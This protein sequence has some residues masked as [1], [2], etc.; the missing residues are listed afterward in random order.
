MKT[1]SDGHCA[2]NSFALGLHN[3]FIK[4]ASAEDF[5]LPE[6][7]VN[8]AIEMGEEWQSKKDI[9]D[10]LSVTREEILH[11]LAHPYSAQPKY[12][13]IIQRRL[14]PIFRRMALEYLEKHYE[15]SSLDASFEMAAFDYIKYD[16]EATNPDN[17]F[18]LIPN[19][20]LRLEHYRQ[21]Q[22]TYAQLLDWWNTTGRQLYF[23]HMK[24]GAN[25]DPSTWGSQVEL[26]VLAAIFHVN[27]IFTQSGL[28]PQV[29]GFP[30]GCIDVGA[31]DLPDE[32]TEDTLEFL[33]N[34]N[35]LSK[36]YGK[37]VF[38]KNFDEQIKE[39]LYLKQ[40]K[41]KLLE[42]AARPLSIGEWLAEI[43]T[44]EHDRVVSILKAHGVLT[45]GYAINDGSINPITELQTGAPLVKEIIAR[46]SAVDERIVDYLR[47]YYIASQPS[48]RVNLEGNHWSF[49]QGHEVFR[50]R[51]SES[52]VSENTRQPEGIGLKSTLH[53]VTYQLALLLLIFKRAMDKKLNF[54]EATEWD[55][56][57]KFDDAVI[58]FQDPLAAESKIILHAY[59]AKHKQDDDSMITDKDLFDMSGGDFSLFK[60]FL[61]FL[62]LQREK[63][64]DEVI[65]DVV[66]YTNAGIDFDAKAKEID[67]KKLLVEA[68]V[69]NAFIQTE[70]A[71]DG[72]HYKFDLTRKE[73]LKPLYQLLQQASQLE[74]LAKCLAEHV[75]ANKSFELRD[76]ILKMYHLALVNQIF[77]LKKKCFMPNFIQDKTGN[78]VLTKLLQLFRENLI[79]LY[80]KNK[81]TDF[82]K[83][84]E[85]LPIKK[86]K[87][88][89][90]FGKVDEIK[91]SPK[92]KNPENSA[93]AFSENEAGNVV[94]LNNK[95]MAGL[96]GKQ[97]DELRGHIIVVDPAS[98]QL[99]FST[100]FCSG[101]GLPGNLM[102][103]RTALIRNLGL[104]AAQAE[105]S[106]KQYTLVIKDF[107]TCEDGDIES[108]AKLPTEIIGD[109]ITPT[110]IEEFLQHLTFS[111]NQP[112]EIELFN[113]LQAELG[114]A[115]NVINSEFIA[116]LFQKKMLDWLKLKKGTFL[117]EKDGEEM[118]KMARSLLSN[119]VLMGQTLE[120][121]AQV[122]QSNIAF[123]TAF[124]VGE[125]LKHSEQVHLINCP[126]GT[127]LTGIKLFKSIKAIDQ[128]QADDSFIFL[129]VKSALNLE[130]QLKQAFSKTS[131]LVIEVDKNL[132]DTETARLITQFE[133][134][135]SM[136][137]EIKI[138][139]LTQDDTQLISEK[140]KLAHKV[141]EDSA[142]DFHALTEESKAYLLSKRVTING[143][144]KAVSE[145][146]EGD[147]DW[148][149]STVVEDL[150]TSPDDSPI[151][152][153]LP[154]TTMSHFDLECYVDRIFERRITLDETV[155]S[156]CSDLILYISPATSETDQTIPDGFTNVIKFLKKYNLLKKQLKATEDKAQRTELQKSLDKLI[157]STTRLCL[158]DASQ[159]NHIARCLN[160]AFKNIQI[161]EQDRKGQLLWKESCG[162]IEGVRAYFQKAVS[163]EHEETDFSDISEHKIIAAEPGMG[164]SAV[165]Q[166]ML[167]SDQAAAKKSE[168]EFEFLV[169]NIDLSKSKTFINRQN[170]SNDNSIIQFLTKIFNLPFLGIHYL[171][172]KLKQ[173]AVK[174]YLDGFD[175]INATQQEK[176]CKFLK[177][178]QVT[179]SGNKIVV[180]TRRHKTKQLEDALVTVAYSLRQVQMEEQIVY[181]KNY[182]SE[183]F[184]KQFEHID[185]VRV[186]Q[187]ARFVVEKFSKDLND[188][189]NEF[190]GIPLQLRL[191]AESIQE[192]C[193]E[194]YLSD[195]AEPDAKLVYDKIAFY[196]KII[197]KKIQI[198]F[199]EKESLSSDFKLGLKSSMKQAII[200]V[201][202]EIAFQLL[203][204]DSNFAQEV[205]S[206]RH[207]SAS[208]LNDIGLVEEI[209]GEF[210]FVHRTYGEYLAAYKIL[211]LL[212]VEESIQK[213]S[214][215]IK[216]ILTQ[217]FTDKGREAILKFIMTMLEKSNN[218]RLLENWNYIISLSLLPQNIMSGS[219]KSDSTKL[220][221]AYTKKNKHHD[222]EQDLSSDE[223]I[224]DLDELLNKEI[225][226]AKKY[227]YGY[228]NWSRGA[229]SGIDCFVYFFNE[230]Y[231]QFSIEQMNKALD[232][233]YLLL[234][235]NKKSTKAKA[236]I[237][238]SLPKFVYHYINLGFFPEK[239][240]QYENEKIF[241]F[242]KISRT[243]AASSTVDLS[244][245]Q[246]SLDLAYEKL[247]Q[248][249]DSLPEIE[250]LLN[251]D[252]I[253]DDCFT[254]LTMAKVIYLGMIYKVRNLFLS[255]DEIKVLFEH[256]EQYRNVSFYPQ[257]ILMLD[258]EN[259][260]L[261]NDVRAQLLAKDDYELLESLSNKFST[262]SYEIENLDVFLKPALTKTQILYLEH[263]DNVFNLDQLRRLKEQKGKFELK[264]Y[265]EEV[266][267]Q[268]AYLRLFG[269]LSRHNNAIELA[270][271]R[272]FAL[273][274]KL[275]PLFEILNQQVSDFKL[276]ASDVQRLFS[277]RSFFWLEE[278]GIRFL[279]KFKCLNYEVIDSLTK[280][281]EEY[282]TNGCHPIYASKI[283]SN[284]IDA[285][286]N[287]DNL[288]S[289]NF[290]VY[291]YISLVHAFFRYRLSPTL[292]YTSEQMN[293][294]FQLFSTAFSKEPIHKK[295]VEYLAFLLKDIATMAGLQIFQFD[296]ALLIV[297]PK[298]DYHFTMP[299]KAY[300][301]FIDCIK[302]V[303]V[304]DKK[305]MSANDYRRLTETN[306]SVDEYQ[307]IE[308]QQR[309]EM[310]IPPI[311]RPDAKLL[312]KGIV[313]RRKLKSERR[314]FLF[315]PTV[316]AEIMGAG[317]LARATAYLA[318]LQTD[319][320]HDAMQIYRKKP[321]RAIIWSSSEQGYTFFKSAPGATDDESCQLEGA[322]NMQLKY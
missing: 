298:G 281:I 229:L 308:A 5:P 74:Q 41:Q 94:T 87:F 104:E 286:L 183:Q 107:A 257:L 157:N 108:F 240:E 164:K 211:S 250:A 204:T 222:E 212:S 133:H 223:S 254:P 285:L 144:T 319:R 134:E 115:F 169:L 202:C 93:K 119:M 159:M 274:D 247:K 195:K 126:Q 46:L 66:I 48:T 60:Y 81:N 24:Q 18:R 311:E 103:F 213:N 11:W 185:E 260:E 199:N 53:G 168:S 266:E 173:G 162:S 123:K 316:M 3:L 238:E 95:G 79:I 76:S 293:V 99:K 155:L 39:V 233:L 165:I 4:H 296:Q 67:L 45:S 59:Q 37:Y 239:S 62:K 186:E 320:L 127:W 9:I 314:D 284:F 232:M 299:L 170:F 73:E 248:D 34:R 196:E 234:F 242:F 287:T 249:V 27:L 208:E 124:P 110:Q 307:K 176:I 135:L 132:S 291:A 152:V 225:K 82:Q 137:A 83:D 146:F 43:S 12:F 256:Y 205:F 276:L 112:N 140:I 84:W 177:C 224:Q 8:L 264:S 184:S 38:E 322:D 279:C 197:S 64:A 102:A 292:V 302:A 217:V 206:T 92:L 174:L 161:I 118:F 150:V 58:A 216:F 275:L 219:K 230:N 65:G 1:L 270:F 268:E 21:N 192:D 215:L 2:F 13:D 31:E 153:M 209:G 265:R 193:C 121:K 226:E 6:S 194:F 261:I 231:N 166:H 72:K 303:F 244:A 19:I 179:F 85:A 300:D 106:L 35:I 55:K 69:E 120:Y 131:L 210:K 228:Q 33:C 273:E 158:L 97:L 25:G 259:A 243:S 17:T 78:S 98:E 151:E 294:L 125:L 187:F 310:D 61:S 272:E 145:W 149:N 56:A 269:K 304:N 101:E 306:G 148:I 172:H 105:E 207:F 22:I 200:E 130:A 278:D 245:E 188:S 139:L 80:K 160:A 251:K 147:V 68:E 116:G 280:K 312:L 7:F 318:A 236:T 305:H 180:A 49:H 136:D 214:K 16:N 253:P 86:L 252:E 88:S 191:I 201:H 109:E 36:K 301:L 117:T 42:Y 14:A 315:L 258:P 309:L 122:E 220:T 30:H 283:V 271:V 218:I 277:E 237:F 189:E 129:K 246:A 267:Y 10:F 111:V 171:S 143:V 156:A 89:N 100:A 235:H 70:A 142:D 54:K 20:K 50:K 241:R 289:A 28:A 182:W 63:E 52:L 26:D 203:F 75:Y 91:E 317:D 40:L 51:Q 71:S 138:L 32:L 227:I 23:T 57:D 321:Q 163:V 29:L 167:L 297:D 44:S 141:H 114:D 198:Y 15:A 221:I 47:K 295:V 313:H 263:S 290:N 77:D 181:L 96:K 262:V 175:E 255:E 154:E 90:G 282:N 113:N 128:F 190:M 288:K 178:L